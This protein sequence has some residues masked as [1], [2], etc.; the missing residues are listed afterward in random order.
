MVQY[1]SKG[2]YLLPSVTHTEPGG[3]HLGILPPAGLR[4]NAGFDVE[5]VEDEACLLG[6]SL[7]VGG[8]LTGVEAAVRQSHS[9]NNDQLKLQSQ[10]KV[11]SSSM[12][13]RYLLPAIWTLTVLTLAF[14]F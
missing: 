5:T 4:E 14:P 7:A 9:L 13:F 11:E 10:S 8:L 6:A 12:N 2:L 3:V 1:V